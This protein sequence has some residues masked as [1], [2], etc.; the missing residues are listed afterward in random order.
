MTNPN[1]VLCRIDNRLVYGQ[2]GVKWLNYS[3]ANLLIV[4]DD[5]VAKDSIQQKIMKLTA[6]NYKVQIRFFYHST[7]S[8]DY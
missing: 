4:V 8:R 1:I 5:Q 3:G 2:V 6:D 7:Y